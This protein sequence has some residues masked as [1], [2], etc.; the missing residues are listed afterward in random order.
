MLEKSNASILSCLIY[1]CNIDQETRLLMNIL[2]AISDF[3]ELDNIMGWSRSDRSV[4]FNFE[5]AGGLDALED[6]QR[7]KN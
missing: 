7:H 1:G 2:E 3:L 4:A 6:A 5:R